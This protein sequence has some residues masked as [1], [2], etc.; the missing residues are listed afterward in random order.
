MTT[1]SPLVLLRLPK[2]NTSPPPAVVSMHFREGLAL[3][4]SPARTVARE[5]DMR[6]KIAPFGDHMAGVGGPKAVASKRRK[7]EGGRCKLQHRPSSLWGRDTW[8]G[9]VIS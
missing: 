3:A 1:S 7:Q 6:G 4:S 8:E 5:A 9:S 2:R